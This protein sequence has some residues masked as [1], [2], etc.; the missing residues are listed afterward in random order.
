MSK[1][2]PEVADMSVFIFRGNVL[3]ENYF[4]NDA[5]VLH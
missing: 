5:Q 3:N 4:A 1:E 2:H